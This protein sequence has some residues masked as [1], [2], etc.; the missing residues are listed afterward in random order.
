MSGYGMAASGAQY[1]T[2]LGVNAK[3]KTALDLVGVG[4]H[5]APIHLVDSRIQRL[6]TDTHCGV[7]DLNLALT[8]LSAARVDHR[9]LRE[10]RLKSLCE[11]EYHLLWR[12][13]HGRAD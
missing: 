7:V 11:R 8:D 12:C 1:A 13:A 9:Q 5:R 6:E 4:R 3:S 2:S 10:S